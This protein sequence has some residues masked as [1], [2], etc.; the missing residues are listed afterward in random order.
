ME[1]AKILA[2][3]EERREVVEFKMI[4]RKIEEYAIKGY[5]IVAAIKILDQTVFESQGNI[6]DIIQEDG[7][8]KDRMVELLKMNTGE[9]PKSTEKVKLPPLFAPLDQDDWWTEKL[10][11][12]QLL[13]YLAILDIGQGCAR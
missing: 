7:D 10:L 8:F 2:A 13:T 12:A 4:K 11:E 9:A 5:S 6:V 3:R 1:K